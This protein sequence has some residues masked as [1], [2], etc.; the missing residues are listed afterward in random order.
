MELT[1]MSTKFY[2]KYRG[3]V[4]NNADPMKLGRVQV[5]VPSVLGTDQLSW[6]MPCVPYA[7]T[8]VGLFMI[9]PIGANIWVEFE[10]GNINYPIWSGCFWGEGELPVEAI[11][12]TQKL[13]K[14]AAISLL[15]DDTEGNGTIALKITPPAI[16]MPLS[17]TL[18]N[19]GI[20]LDATPATLKLTLES[21]AMQLGGAS[22]DMTPANIAMALGSA[23][24]D[25]TP[26]NI[27]MAL[28]S[29]SIDMTPSIVNIVPTL[30]PPSVPP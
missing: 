5:I 17:I 27:A 6:A 24:I 4:G 9:P 21:I 14:T 25:V 13:I 16:K 23:S 7:G 1:T 8:Q 12:P 26:A 28:G 11:L 20:A 22:I 19:N 15:L 2:G 29:A 3:K 18:N 30:Q 10:G